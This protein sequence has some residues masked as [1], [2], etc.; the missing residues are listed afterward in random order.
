MGKRIA[1][2]AIDVLRE[3]NNDGVSWGDSGLLDL[4]YVRADMKLKDDRPMNR[5]K[6][7][8]AALD[9]APDLFRKSYWQAN[10]GGRTAYVRDFHAR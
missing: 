1:E 8:L 3:T 7:V 10:V 5:H 9:R 4:I 6:Q 2:H